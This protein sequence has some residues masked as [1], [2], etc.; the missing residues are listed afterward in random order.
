MMK[1]VFSLWLALG[2]LVACS[3]PDSSARR[4][5]TQLRMKERCAEVGL[6]ARKDWVGRYHG[7]TF[8]DSPEYGYSERLNTCLYADE[9]DDSGGG[10]AIVGASSRR[11]LF[12]LDV[13]ANKILAEYTEHDGRSITTA[14]DPVMCRTEEEFVARK[15]LLFGR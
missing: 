10:A 13:L 2:V 5:E 8:S 15:A 11:D 12:V 6:K 3:D 14:V 4:Q 7:E 1:R 9:Y